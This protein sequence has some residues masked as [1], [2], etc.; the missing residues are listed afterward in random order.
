MS[1]SVWGKS[2][3]GMDE[4][5]ERNEAFQRWVRC[6]ASEHATT[7]PLGYLVPKV[8]TLRTGIAHM[9]PYTS[10]HSPAQALDFCSI[11]Q[12]LVHLYCVPVCSFV[13]FFQLF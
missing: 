4:V 10:T 2:E 9:V 8:L 12:P 13:H 11:I 7:R 6:L 3:Y 5:I 1:V